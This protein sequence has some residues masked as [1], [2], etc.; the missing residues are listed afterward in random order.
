M[1]LRTQCSLFI[2][3]CCVYLVEAAMENALHLLLVKAG[4]L[5]L[6]AGVL[7]VECECFAG[8]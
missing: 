6:S 8:S 2:V 3:M 7:V 4:S 5:D 1:I